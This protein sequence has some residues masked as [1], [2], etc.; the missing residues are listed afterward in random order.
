MRIAIPVLKGRLATSFKYFEQVILLDTDNQKIKVFECDTG[1]PIFNCP[2]GTDR[3]II[4]FSL[5]YKV[6]MSKQHSI[7]YLNQISSFSLF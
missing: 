7:V 5:T 1:K 4:R 2:V 3:S 6:V